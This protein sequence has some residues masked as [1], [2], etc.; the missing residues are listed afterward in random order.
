MGARRGGRSRHASAQVSFPRALRLLQGFVRREGHAFVP[1]WHVERGFR[2]GQWVLIMRGLHRR[3]TLPEQR[4][5]RLA[6]LDGWCWDARPDSFARGL[7]ALRAFAAREGHTRMRDDHI[8]QGIALGDW[9]GRLRK[10]AANGTLSE[11]KRAQL[12]T[13]PG[14]ERRPRQEQFAEGLRRLNA[15]VKKH[16]HAHVQDHT[17]WGGPDIWLALWVK[18]QRKAYRA[19]R[20]ARD[21][22][23]ALEALPGWTWGASRT[24][25]SQRPA[26]G[27]RSGGR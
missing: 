13:I 10:A 25:G 16:G 14:W 18:R 1:V 17:R 19:G 11:A 12:D 6:R 9:L 22:I 2:L 4:A 5:R 20:L 3:G 21:R 27:P 8:D 26:S 23:R 7:V 15:F 24:G